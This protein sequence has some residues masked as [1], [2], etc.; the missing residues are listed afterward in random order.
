MMNTTDLIGQW[1]MDGAGGDVDD[2]FGS[3]VDINAR[4]SEREQEA[5]V[6]PAPMPAPLL[7]K[8]ADDDD[9]RPLL[10]AVSTG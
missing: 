3:L 9:W 5:H 1:S 7:L 8:S 2:S 6:E 4:L 10:G